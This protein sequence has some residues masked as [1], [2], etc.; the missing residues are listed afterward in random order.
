MV[1]NLKTLVVLGGIVLVVGGTMFFGH[2]TVPP[3]KEEDA[4]EM[5]MVSP[6][7]VVSSAP[8]AAPIYYPQQVSAPTVAPLKD[9][10]TSSTN[11]SAGSS[12][13]TP[14]PTTTFTYATPAPLPT[15]QPT[16]DYTAQNTANYNTCE[17]NANSYQS[18]AVSSC[19][20]DTLCTRSV[21]ADYSQQLEQCN[22]MYGKN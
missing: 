11:Y 21:E 4:I 15:A 1:T 22:T 5:P 2:S 3:V 7:P 14:Y 20:G 10:T 9:Q 18:S 6:T 12:A 19:G 8:S 13:D 17:Q 16:P